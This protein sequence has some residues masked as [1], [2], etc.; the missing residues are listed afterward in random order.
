MGPNQMRTAGVDLGGTTSTVRVFDEHWQ[1]VEEESSRTPDKYDELIALACAQVDLAKSHAATVGFG[2][3]GVVNA[4][5]ELFAANLPVE[6]RRFRSDVVAQ[7]GNVTWINDSGAIALSE[8][9]FGAGRSASSIMSLTLGTG[10]AGGQVSKGAF[11]ESWSGWGREFGHIGVSAACLSKLNLPLRV[12]PCGRAG[13]VERYIS[14][15]GLEWL[16]VHKTGQ[17]LT[18]REVAELRHQEDSV[19]EVWTLWCDLVADL[20][21][22]VMHTIDPERIVVGGGLSR[23]A[24]VDADLSE[25]LGELHYP[26]F[27]VPHLCIAEG[28]AESGARGAAYAA[29]LEARR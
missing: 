3:P 6:G 23:I 27:K 1:I 11:V 29:Y 5:G 20:L 16:A 7:C 19:K 12:C 25:A 10:V 15:P 24:G 28:G 4:E 18:T 21:V 9:V 22:T 8:A 13:C 2:H 14:G 26:G 17:S